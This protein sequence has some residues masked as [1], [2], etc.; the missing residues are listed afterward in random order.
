M[1]QLLDILLV[2]LNNSRP[3]KYLFDI[4]TSYSFD[5]STC[6]ELD[7]LFELYSSMVFFHYHCHY[8]SPRNSKTGHIF[9]DFLS[10]KFREVPKKLY[11][12]NVGI[13]YIEQLRY[14]RCARI[15]IAV[16]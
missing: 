1:P 13:S 10:K 7:S 5:M 8:K 15:Y 16:I 9:K 12:S 14:L 11:H 6:N 3:Y 4:D 2:P